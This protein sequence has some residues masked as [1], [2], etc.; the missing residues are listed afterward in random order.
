MLRACPV[1]RSTSDSTL[2]FVSVTTALL[3]VLRLNA[4]VVANKG[5]IDF[6]GSATGTKRRQITRAH[7]FA[8]AMPHEPSGFQGNAQSA[9][10][11]VGADTLLAGGNKEDGLEPQMQ[12]DVARFEDGANLN[13]ERFAAVVALVHAYSGA[14][15]LQ[16]AAAI[17]GAA[18]RTNATVWPN[19]RFDEI[20]CGLFV[21]EVWFGKH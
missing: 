10:K 13:G 18:V 15:A 11:L 6:D 21:V 7:G 17:N 20:I 3:I 19:T 5:L 9:M 1:S 16:L 12:L 8:N 14:L 2:C 4:A